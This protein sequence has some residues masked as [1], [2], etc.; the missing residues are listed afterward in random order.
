MSSST[1]IYTVA[2]VFFVVG[3]VFSLIQPSHLTNPLNW[4]VAA[5]CIVAIFSGLPVLK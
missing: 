5:I 2:L 4:F 1:V 3:A